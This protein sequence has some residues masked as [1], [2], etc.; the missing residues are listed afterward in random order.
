[1]EFQEKDLVKCAFFGDKIFVLEKCD[2]ND[3]CVGFRR[4]SLFYSFL[5]DGR[6]YKHHTA[7]VLTLVERPAQKIKKRFWQWAI[8][9]QDGYFK[10][11]Y[12]YDDTGHSTNDSKYKKWNDIKKIKLE[13]YFIDIEVDA[14]KF[15]C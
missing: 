11:G 12:F 10:T 13:N 6:Y 8:E 1:M 2:V 7:P 15:K 9:D 14:E 4:N 5:S 3:D